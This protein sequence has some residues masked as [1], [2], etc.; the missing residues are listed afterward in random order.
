MCRWRL[1]R[2]PEHLWCAD[3]WLKKKSA[4]R[5][6]VRYPFD[7]TAKIVRHFVKKDYIG[8]LVRTHVL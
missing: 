8:F 7:K 1:I 6:A 4:V 5:K 3:G 2:L